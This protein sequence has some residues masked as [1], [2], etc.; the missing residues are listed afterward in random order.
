VILTIDEIAKRTKDLPVF[1]PAA[2]EVMMATGAADACPHQVAHLL[3]KDQS[4]AIKV[5]R[6]ANSSYY[7]LPRKITSLEQAVVILGIR[8]IR[9]L[10]LAAATY[11][12][13]VRPLSGYNLGPKDLWVHSFAVGMAA[14]YI[15]RKVRGVDADLALTCGLIHDIG[16]VT[17]SIWLESKASAL[18]HYAQR[19]KLPF[20]QVEVKVLGFD[21]TQ[22]G[23]LLAENWNIPDPMVKVIRWHHQPSRC[24]EPAPLVDCVHCGIEVIRRMGIGLV[25]QGLL[26]AFDPS[27]PDRL[28]ITAAQLNSAADFV[29]EHIEEYRSLMEE[30]AA[31]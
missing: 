9:N 29:K 13:L 25:E 2:Q 30:P 28:G 31:A 12:W 24:P 7:G 10:S 27:S 3:M 18:M 16:M 20:D 6:L 11:P 17:L 23:A 4:L 26:Y 19:E 5:L 1:S 22:V 8:S 15:A 14:S 21:H